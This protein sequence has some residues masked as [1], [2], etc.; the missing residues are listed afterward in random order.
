MCGI[1]G[2]FDPNG[3]DQNILDQV[4]QMGQHLI[5][6]GPDSSGHWQS[7]DRKYAVAH[8]RLAII[9]LSNDGA[10]PM[11]S[12]SGRY[13][14]SFNGEIYNYSELRRELNL[15]KLA[16][17][18]RGHSDTEVLLAAIENFGFEKTL[19]KVRGM[20]SIALWD[21]KN[22]TLSLA[23]DRF[24]EKPL[25]YGW[26]NGK[27]I[28]ASELKAFR[29]NSNNKFRID[30]V[31]VSLM[32]RF[33]Y[34]PSP[35]SIYEGIEKLPPGSLLVIGDGKK[36]EVQSQR[37]FGLENEGD[38]S[39]Q[40]LISKDFFANTDTL[41]CLLKSAVSEQMLADVPLGVML[42]GGV[43]SS[44]IAAL[45]QANSSVSI[46]TFTIG[47]KEEV[48]DETA[49]ATAVARHLGTNHN[50]I[51]VS[52]R[53]AL[54]IVPELP[55]IYDEPFGDSSQVATVLLSRMTSE[56][57]T[58]CLTGDGADELFGGYNR[59]IWLHGL[60]KRTSWIPQTIKFQIIAAL[61]SVPANKWNKLFTKLNFLLPN[62][63]QTINP[64]DK[65]HKIGQILAADS[66]VEAFKKAISQWNDDLAAESL[67]GENILVNNTLSWPEA[68]TFVERM[69]LIDCLTYLPDDILTKVDRA[70][71][72]SSIETRAPFLDQRVASFSTKLPL[73]QKIRG[74]SGKRILKSLLGQYL[75]SD[76]FARP[77]Q[78]FSVPIEYWLRGPL[79]EWSE[80]LLSEESLAKS[81]FLNP[82]A[83]RKVWAQH[84]AGS[85]THHAIWN[86]LMF[87]AWFD[88]QQM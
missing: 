36:V 5:H 43:D 83:I 77:K 30:Q 55:V 4:K 27:L 42:S 16:P 21:N 31:A 81:G 65:I 2:I 41:G 69:M 12:Q 66:E 24:G 38:N 25:Y 13:V 10:Q 73:D 59:Y 8:R 37:W 79:R 49:H 40:D 34:V 46:N 75:P 67:G 28:F 29:A 44:L 17:T 86:V 72:A 85:N 64:G 7:E 23:R 14:I 20:F 48:Y 47:F 6:R 53:D 51:F 54:D 1:A 3:K 63:I 78:G 39:S 56:H 19:L 84:L 45:M 60:W 76:I 9:D 18:W 87:Q 33:G 80:S 57:V 26:F 35:L 82:I 11:H 15:L 22:H 58:V 52:S 71:M 62:I 74:G 88:S 32:L 61:R 50:Q 68:N 70:S